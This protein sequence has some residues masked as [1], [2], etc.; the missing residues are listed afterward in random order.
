MPEEVTSRNVFL[1]VPY[2]ASVTLEP[3]DA[4][5]VQIT[6][7]GALTLA[8]PTRKAAGLEIVIELIQDGTGGRV[9]TFGTDFKVNWTP[10]TTLGLRNVIGFYCD[11]T[12]WIQ[13]QTAIGLPA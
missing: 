10:T 1:V 13:Q 11:G 6:L 4:D 9:T 7:T 8:N 5:F 2:A 3:A 12:F